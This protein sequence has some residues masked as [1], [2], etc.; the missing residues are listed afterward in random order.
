MVAGLIR[1]ARRLRFHDA[2][3]RQLVRIVG[4]YN[5]GVPVGLGLHRF[6][7]PCWWSEATSICD[8]SGAGSAATGPQTELCALPEHETVGA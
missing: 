3:R 8:W 1:C 2:S 4:P 7:A 5:A 6:D